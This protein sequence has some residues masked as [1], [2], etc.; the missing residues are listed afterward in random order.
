[1]DECVATGRVIPRVDEPSPEGDPLQSAEVDKIIDRNWNELLQEL[2]V[3]QT[4]TQ[5]LTGFLLTV[6]FSNGFPKLEHG[7]KILYL[8]VL[9]GSVIATGL[10]VAP[11][12]YHRVLFRQRKRRWLVSAA[13][14]SARAALLMLALDSAG[15]VLLVFDVVANRT[16]AII[17]AG[18]SLL[19]FLVL[20]GAVPLAV[21]GQKR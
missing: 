18:G 6:P 15:V 8:L 3:T 19:F 21:R 5:I 12:A 4:G 13:N 14:V 9:L 16:A 20:W 2:R 10:N 7:Q 17:A 1:V 11:V